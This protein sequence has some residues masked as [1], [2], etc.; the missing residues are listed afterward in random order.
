MR[1]GLVQLVVR[2][3]AAAP[4]RLHVVHV[5]VDDRSVITGDETPAGKSC[6]TEQVQKRHRWF[7]GVM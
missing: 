5:A 3:D 2:A 1:E 7:P 6:K 4:V